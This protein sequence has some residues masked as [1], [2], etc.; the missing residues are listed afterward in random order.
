ML[1]I[2]GPAGPFML[3]IHDIF[4][5]AGPFMHPDQIFLYRLEYK[6]NQITPDYIPA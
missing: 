1:D 5:P 4:G 2:F 6:T 3:D